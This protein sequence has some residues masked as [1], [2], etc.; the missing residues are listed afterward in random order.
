MYST[1]TATVT[2][3]YTDTLTVGAKIDLRK[4]MIDVLIIEDRCVDL[5]TSIVDVKLCCYINLLK[6]LIL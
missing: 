2:L 4:L 1:R 5:R 3:T 6:T